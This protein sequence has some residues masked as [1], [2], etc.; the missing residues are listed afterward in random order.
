MTELEVVTYYLTDLKK[1]ISKLEDD[2]EFYTEKLKNFEC[3]SA[4]D[5][6]FYIWKIG[7]KN[8][9]IIKATER[10]LA[11]VKASRIIESAKEAELKK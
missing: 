6:D 8:R 3:I 11:L 2:K 10:I 5:E 4:K 9:E 1:Y 7:K